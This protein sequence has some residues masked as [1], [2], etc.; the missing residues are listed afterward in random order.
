[1]AYG[2]QRSLTDGKYGKRKAK[3]CIDDQWRRSRKRSARDL[4]TSSCR[5][6]ATFEVANGCL[7]IVCRVSRS[8][9]LGAMMLK[10]TGL[11][12]VVKQFLAGSY[13]ESETVKVVGRPAS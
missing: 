11:A 13:G 9:R 12:S 5:E 6:G 7:L 10:R 8:L 4:A 3:R 1:M 2:R